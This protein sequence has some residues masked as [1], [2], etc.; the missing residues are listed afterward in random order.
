MQCCNK[1]SSF[2]AKPKKIQPRFF[3]LIKGSTFI[4]R[5]A[6]RYMGTV[7]FKLHCAFSL[8]FGEKEQ[9]ATSIPLDR[10]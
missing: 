8:H 6:I 10:N 3:G 1:S 4:S 9:I 5:W 2:E 7:V